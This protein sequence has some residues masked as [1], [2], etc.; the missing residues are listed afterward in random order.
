M[1]ARARGGSAHH[2][3]RQIQRLGHRVLLL[4]SHQTR[5]Y[6]LRDKTDNCDY[7]SQKAA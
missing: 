7:R 6:V 2:W 4:P 3:A 5:R 1:S